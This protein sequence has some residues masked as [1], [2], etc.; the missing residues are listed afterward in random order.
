LLLPVPLHP[1]RLTERGCNQALE[2]ARPLARHFRLPLETRLIQRIRATAAQTTLDAD[3]RASNPHHAFRLDPKRLAQ[4]GQVQRVA[5]IDDVMTTG[6]TLHE[7]TRLL[8][9]AGIATV[10]YWVTAR[11]I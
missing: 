11:T 8:H 4:L 10:E 3:A 9:N 7:I 6:A 5:L 2:I 1:K